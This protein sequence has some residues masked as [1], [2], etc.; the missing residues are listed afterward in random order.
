MMCPKCAAKTSV[1]A[2]RTPTNPGKGAEVNRG[3]SLVGWYTPEFVVRRRVCKEC[4]CQFY[5]IEISFDDM[6]SIIQESSDGHA[7]NKPKSKA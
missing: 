1:T 3:N 6:S 4:T 2:T 5:T 7:P